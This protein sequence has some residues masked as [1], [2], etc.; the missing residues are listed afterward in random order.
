MISKLWIFLS[1]QVLEISTVDH[2]V[3]CEDLNEVATWSLHLYNSPRGQSQR[4][5]SL[6]IAEAYS[7][8]RLLP[9]IFPDGA[10]ADPGLV[11]QWVRALIPTSL[12][13]TICR[14]SIDCACE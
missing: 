8:H 6:T 10:T 2:Q 3:N 12:Q 7:V 1:I 11:K 5:D 9:G 4:R 14:T 13:P